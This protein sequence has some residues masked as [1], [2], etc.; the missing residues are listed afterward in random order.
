ML[1]WPCAD[2]SL[3]S[4]WASFEMAA[5]RA[6]TSSRTASAYL[7]SDSSAV[8]GNSYFRNRSRAVTAVWTLSRLFSLAISSFSRSILVTNPLSKRR[9]VPSRFAFAW[10]SSFMATCKSSSNF[11]SFCLASPSPSASILAYGEKS[12]TTEG[13]VGADSVL[14][15]SFVVIPAATIRFV[16]G[17]VTIGP[18]VGRLEDVPVAGNGTGLAGASFVAAAGGWW[19]S[20]RV[21][22]EA[23]SEERRVGEEGRCRGSPDP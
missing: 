12:M 18:A 11:R 1:Y 16:A 19:D 2:L 6:R 15:G 17:T 8:L 10:P 3:A 20:A 7:D 21:G 4:A 22:S 9:L 13:V 23:R 5:L 14:A